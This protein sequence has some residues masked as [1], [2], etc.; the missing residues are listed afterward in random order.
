ML[1]KLMLSVLGGSIAMTVLMGAVELSHP[2]LAYTGAAALLTLLLL[3]L[4]GAVPRRLLLDGT[5]LQ[6]WRWGV[7]EVLRAA[8][9][10][11]PLAIFL[12][13]APIL[14]VV[15]IVASMSAIGLMRYV[16]R[17]ILSE[18]ARLRG[19]GYLPAQPLRVQARLRWAN[20]ALMGMFC[21]GLSL[22]ALWGFI[23]GQPTGLILALPAIFSLFSLLLWFGSLM[24]GR[25]AEE[26]CYQEHIA[27]YIDHCLAAG[28]RDAIHYAGGS[29][30]RVKSIAGRIKA[31][32]REVVILSR[33]VSSHQRAIKKGLKSFLVRRLSDLDRFILPCLEDIHY[34]SNT[35]RAGHVVRFTDARHIL[36]L[37]SVPP[38]PRG[39]PEYLAMYDA[40][41]TT[42][43]PTDI[44]AA[45]A[46]AWVLSC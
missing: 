8:A 32:K 40:L 29:V 30:D 12:P 5:K 27:D 42:Q 14:S 37:S 35:Q 19:L 41:A 9:V 17:K 3:A 36:H 46:G 20:S 2:Q 11:A 43:R 23:C 18:R 21:L 4:W 24:A 6:G 44:E 31:R 38:S 13:A 7:F 45:H 34:S 16:A 33:D 10:A 15:G 28:V 39:F 22:S 26:R 25:E 1:K